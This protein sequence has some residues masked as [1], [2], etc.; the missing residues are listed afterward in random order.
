MSSTHWVLKFSNVFVG[1]AALALLNACATH[2]SEKDKA[3]YYESS[4]DDHNRA[5]AS[6]AP[7]I[8]YGAGETLDPV[9]MRTQ[10]DYHFAM[11]KPLV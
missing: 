3:V 11:E 9:Y 4:F 6:V 5:P 10:A 2:P 8:A 7:R 1:L